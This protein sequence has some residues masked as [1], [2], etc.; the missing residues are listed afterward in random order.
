M[1]R[2]IRSR[3]I[4]HLLRTGVL[5]CALL[6]P[7]GRAS[8]QSIDEGRDSLR[9]GSYDVAARLLSRVPATSDEWPEAQQLAVRALRNVGKYQEAEDAARRATTSAKGKELWNTLGE[10]LYERGK[11]SDAESAFKRAVSEHASDSLT[12]AV[13]LAVLHYSRGQV[14]DAMKEFDRFIDLYNSNSSRLTPAEIRAVAVACRYL[15]INDPQLFKDA[16][17][18]Y[19]RAIA[20]A[21]DDLEPQVELGELF[22]EKNNS[23]DAQKTFAEVLSVNES[24]PRAL[25]GEAR[26][27]DFDNQ[28]GADSL[29][30]RALKV[31][32]NFVDG[33][34]FKAQLALDLEEYAAA[35]REIDRALAVNPSSQ[36]ALSVL[37]AIQRLSGDNAGYDATVKRALAINP[38]DAELYNTVAELTA[39]V[40]QYR[41]AAELAKQ[42]VALDAKS[43]RA[44]KTLGLNQLRLGQIAEGKK[45]LETAFKGDPYD[46]WTKNTLDLLDTYKNYDETKSDHFLF[47]IERSES[48]LLGTYMKELGERAWTTFSARY[49]YTPPPPI[50]IEVYRSHADFSVR[51]VGLAGLG[52]LGVSFGTTLAF[53]SPAA[54]DAGP[55]NWGS[56][57]WHELAHTFTL[58]STNHRIPRW[59][60]EGL[61]VYEEHKAEPGWGFGPTPGFLIA[62]KQGK[63]VPVSRMNDGF[64]HPTY[65]EQVQYSYYQ[66]SLVCELIAKDHG[67]DALRKML[68]GYKS[69]LSTEQVFERVLKT[70]IKTFDKKFDAYMRERFAK[71]LA[72]LKPQLGAMQVAGGDAIA[73]AASDPSDFI[74]QLNA[75]RMLFDG[76]R[77]D[78]AVA[79]LERAKALF[80]EY[81]GDG[82][83]YWYLSQI[84]KR[85]GDT[86]RA[87]QELTSLV[88]MNE[89]DQKAHL[90][91][92]DLLDA[93]GDKAGAAKILERS[94]YINPYDRAQH[95]RLAEMYRGLKDFSKAVRERKAVVALTPVDRPAAL[96]KLAQ[97]QHEAGDD[98]S[99]R[100][101]V[102]R[103]LEDAP[104]YAEAQMLL[105][106]LYE[107]RNRTVKP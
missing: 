99:A 104:N 30:D 4:R 23:G 68:E 81:A 85:K 87:A 49:G 47:M 64:M 98:A 59:L 43:W 92:A 103:S 32:P 78:E 14:D 53:D 74:L 61:S 55:F 72:A 60:S 22:L 71:P 66:A 91:L 65:P 73:R 52:A 10:V 6:V 48:D 20:A 50:R 12:A 29:L 97:A 86:R 83:P 34:V 106:T 101:S 27:R 95:E 42:G 36:E 31:N 40:R 58:G 57:V 35:R 63:L 94:M 51:T 21:T 79:P 100:I 7:V 28:P 77:F 105:L 54:R 2:M 76:G 26:R 69:G 80:P 1:T 33:R 3:G 44:W 62:F 19:D 89:V 9:S 96:Y 38:R 24:H 25:L 37:A 88:N 56:T 39:R 8:A 5:A 15:G 75:G 17:T 67:E 84:A 16:L 11:I 107:A 90:E 41:D 102:L 45:S 13:N 46:V 70:D 82:N 18:A 93:Q